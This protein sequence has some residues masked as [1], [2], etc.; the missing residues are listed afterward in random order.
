MRHFLSHSCCC[1]CCCCGVPIDAWVVAQSSL[2]SSRDA[3][4]VRQRKESNCKK[5]RKKK[6]K[7]GGRAFAFPPSLYP[8]IIII[9]QSILHPPPSLCSPPV[10]L[11]LLLFCLFFC[12][13][14]VCLSVVW[15]YMRLLCSAFALL[16]SLLSM[17]MHAAAVADIVDIVVWPA[18]CSYHSHPPI[19]FHSSILGVFAEFYSK[20]DYRVRSE[21]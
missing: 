3:M 11:L 2:D 15:I 19:R 16:L 7:G 8:I 5:R 17:Q 13:V 9:I 6:G 18:T 12:C 10:S 14:F 1:Y 4:R 20:A 21:K